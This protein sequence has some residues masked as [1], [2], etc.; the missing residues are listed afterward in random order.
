MELVPIIDILAC[1]VCFI[2]NAIILNIFFIINSYCVAFNR[3][4]IVFDGYRIA[5]IIAF[6]YICASPSALATTVMLAKAVA[7]I[8]SADIPLMN[9]LKFIEKFLLF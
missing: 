1:S 8:V 3:L 7:A 5:S 4:R 2:V 6:A 9:F